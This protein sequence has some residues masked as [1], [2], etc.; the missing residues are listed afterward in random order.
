[1]SGTQPVALYALRVPPGGALIPALP[2][3]AAMV[4]LGY[5]VVHLDL[6]AQDEILTPIH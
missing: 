3:V 1:M 6:M 5:L 4:S 2:E